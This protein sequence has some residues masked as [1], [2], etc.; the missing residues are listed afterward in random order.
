MGG[1]GQ[2]RMVASLLE[3]KADVNAVSEAGETPHHVAGIKCKENVVRAL[4]EAR[5]NV[6]THTHGGEAMSMTP[7]HWYVNMKPCEEKQVRMLLDARADVTARNSEGETPFDM[8]SRIKDRQ[9]IAGL[10][11]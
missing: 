5:A 3:K 2:N 7:L 6:N 11:R 4:L 10:V 8:V 1:E 9:H